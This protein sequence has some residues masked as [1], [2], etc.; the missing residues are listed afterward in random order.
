[1]K[2]IKDLNIKVTYWAGFKNAEV[3]DE[4][5]DQLV[6]MEEIGDVSDGEIY[7]KEV[8]TGMDWLANHISEED[9]HSWSY[10]VNVED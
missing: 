10:E 5:Y 1:M 6:K 2:K 3:P 8:D 9:A 7:L 4:V